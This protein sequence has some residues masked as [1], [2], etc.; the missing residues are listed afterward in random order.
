LKTDAAFAN[1]LPSL[2][3]IVPIVCQN[4]RQESP[5]VTNA[6][7]HY[8]TVRKRSASVGAFV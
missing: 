5:L 2:A 1:D 7:N 6:A 4:I 8:K 3:T